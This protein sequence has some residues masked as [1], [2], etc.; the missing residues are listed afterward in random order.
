MAKRRVQVQELKSLSQG[1]VAPTAKPVD[2]YVRPADPQLQ[3][4]ALTEFVA[5]ITP[6]IKAE[7]DMRRAERIKRE[8]RIQQGIYANQIN[9]AKN[10]AITLTEQADLHYQNNRAEYLA[11][12]DDANETAFEKVQKKR[13]AYFDEYIQ[14]L[15]DAGTDELI[16]QSLKDDIALR[17]TAWMYKTYAKAKREDNETKVIEQFKT[18]IQST[19]DS[20]MD[21]DGQVVTVHDLV[22]SFAAAEG[23]NYEK[24]LDAIWEIAVARSATQGDNVLVDWLESN[25]SSPDGKTSQWQSGKR[26]KQRATI[27][28]NIA[29]QEKNGRTAQ[30][31]IDI[32]NDLT[33][34]ATEAYTSGQ[35]GVLEIGIDVPLPN[36]E[37]TRH[38]AQDYAPVI[39][40]LYMQE[41]KQIEETAFETEEEREAAVTDAKRR[42]YGF[43]NNAGTLPVE[44]RQAVNNGVDKL[45][46]GDPTNPENVQLAEQMYKMLDEADAYATGIVT[47]AL[48]G[49]DYTRF[50]HLRALVRGGMEFTT[51]LGKVQ[52]DLYMGRTAAITD[53]SVRSYLDTRDWFDSI[54]NI[55]YETEGEKMGRARNL[56][57]MTDTVSKLAN[58]LM[59]TD[60][61]VTLEAA[62]EQAIQLVAKDFTA[63]QNTDGSVT[64]INME[65]NASK[66]PANITLIQEALVELQEQPVIQEAAAALLSLD[67][68]GAINIMGVDIPMYDVVVR[69]TGNINQL[70]VYIVPKGEDVAVTNEQ[71]LLTSVDVWNFEQNRINNIVDATVRNVN[72]AAQNMPITQQPVVRDALKNAVNNDQAS[73]TTPSMTEYVAQAAEQAG[74]PAEVIQ[75]GIDA[76]EDAGITEDDI[77]TI[78]QG[79][80]PEGMEDFF[81]DV[82]AAL[83]DISF[84]P[85]STAAAATLIEDEGFRSAPYDDMGKDS[86]GYGFQIESLE[87]DERALIKDI[88]DVQP[89]EANA[90]LGL[91]VGKLENWWNN[92]I[93]GF[94]NLPES[95]QVAAISM[96]YQLGKENVAREWP[97]FMA[98]VQEA[99]QYVEGSAEQ[100]AALAEAKFNMLYNKAEN[101]VITATKWATQTTDRAMRMAEGMAASAGEVLSETGD[102]IAENL[103][104]AG[105]GIVNAIM[106]KAQASE[107]TPAIVGEEPKAEAVVAIAGARNPA[108]VAAEYLGMDENTPEGAAAVKGFFENVVGG[109]NP[110]NQSVEEFATS[111]A[112]CAAFLTQ[113]LRDS[114]IDTKALLGKDSFN[115]VRAAAYLKAGDAVEA[116]QVKA[117]DI[118]VKMHSAEDRKKFKL[119]VAHVG[120]VAKVEGNT[121]Y[122]IGGNTG[123]KVELSDYDMTQEDIRFRR[124]SGVTD[125]PTESMPSMLQMKAGKYGRKAVDAISNGFN[126]LY[127]SVFGD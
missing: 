121:V 90:V 100:A 94:S 95:S 19:M 29:R 39:D 118:M 60:M 40:A 107:L 126:S 64:I 125:I 116:P 18:S 32:S 127:D 38:T 69:P 75:Q 91:K 111:K 93:E 21:A 48:K 36:G 13:G 6:A 72:A 117:G 67:Y 55:I 86:V 112:W 61:S 30:K 81:S 68:G 122:F 83:G 26:V 47:T 44:L 20:S 71:H 58:A 12:E 85:V 105:S 92:T 4:S 46:Q 43:Y 7:G 123:D 5:A 53:E 120:I 114:G 59:Q 52:G 87:P 102:V 34:R 98:S 33:A 89:D 16:I 28:A 54:P 35:M 31:K 108:D 57:I 2:T 77:E 11:L 82:R 103:E 106:P 17:D 104:A 74:V 15:E 24:A 37:T 27:E 78:S 65:S 22:N 25:L 3:P 101:G 113:V 97:K 99:A 41:L 1:S 66:D 51:A 10:A 76:A 119:G 80:E 62:T 79:N 124:I 45:T 84:N 56:G 50:Q 96:S 88:N 115:Q 73:V 70:G 42:R 9:Q 14:K 110:D 49:D 8:N 109:W 23:G 63:I